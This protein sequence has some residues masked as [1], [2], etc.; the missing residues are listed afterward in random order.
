L[1]EDNKSSSYLTIGVL[2]YEDPT[3]E[4]YQRIFLKR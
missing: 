2:D 3:E 4:L 1:L